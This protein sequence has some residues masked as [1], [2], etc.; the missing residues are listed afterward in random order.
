METKSWYLLAY[1]VADPKRLQR[2]HYYLRKHA[3]AAQ[4]SVFFLHATPVKLCEVLEAVTKRMRRDQD[5]L[6]AYPVEHPSRVWL[7]GQA[8]V[9]GALLQSAPTRQPGTRPKTRSGKAKSA[10][11][12]AAL[13]RRLWGGRHER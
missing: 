2:V 1:D 8:A 11:G 13:A 12:F 5:D 9:K 3:L 4:R 7:S 6:R 10:R